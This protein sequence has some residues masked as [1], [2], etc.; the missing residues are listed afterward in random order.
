MTYPALTIWQPWAWLIVQGYKDLE[1]R[2]WST[3]HRGTL[4]I[5]AGRRF[6]D[7]FDWEWAQAILE[8]DHNAAMPTSLDAFPLGGIVGRVTLI[9]CA[10]RG[11][12]VEG[13]SPG[14]LFIDDSPWFT[15]RFGWALKD[16]QPRAFQPCRG[17]QGLFKP[18]F[19][20]RR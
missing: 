10:E 20:G 8:R 18:D 3:P 2:S 6:D 15:G 16:P 11:Q 1:N 13:W 5:H 4:Q 17:N 7:D 9:A 19:G 12:R 14:R